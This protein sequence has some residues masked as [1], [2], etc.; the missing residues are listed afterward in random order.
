MP[1]RRHPGP[2]RRPCPVPPAAPT[3]SSSAAGSPGCGPPTTCCWRDPSLDVARPRGRAR[4]LRGERTQRR[5]GLGAVAGRART[6]LARRSR[7]RCRRG[8]AGASCVTRS[9]R[10][11]GQRN[12]RGSTADSARAAPSAWRARPPRS[13]GPGPRWS[14]P[15]EWGIGT[16]WLDADGGDGP[17][18]RRPG[19]GRDLQPALRPGAPAPAR[20]RA[21]RRR[22][23]PGRPHRRGRPRRGIEPAACA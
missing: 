20:R 18:R 7:P 14:T 4:R 13:P 21:R 22:A 3:W 2:P 1:R 23:R 16:R 6:T 19:P 12:P 8:H 17:T 5:L 11:A 15:S 10:W 9:T